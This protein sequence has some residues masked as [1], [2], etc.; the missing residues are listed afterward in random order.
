M[1]G[2]RNKLYLSFWWRRVQGTLCIRNNLGMWHADT[3]V[4]GHSISSNHYSVNGH[5]IRD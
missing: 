3:S 1:R 4:I 2:R 5:F